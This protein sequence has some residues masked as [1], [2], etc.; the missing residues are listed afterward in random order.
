MGGNNLKQSRQLICIYVFFKVSNFSKAMKSYEIHPNAHLQ[1]VASMIKIA[2]TCDSRLMLRRRMMQMQT[3]PMI[4]ALSWSFLCVVFFRT[5]SESTAFLP[6]FPQVQLP[7]M[8]VL[9]TVQSAKLWQLVAAKGQADSA[10]SN[11]SSL[12][13][14]AQTLP[15]ICRPCPLLHECYM[16]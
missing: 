16:L 8:H 12:R 11:C 5:Y 1:D 15:W 10:S 4:Y 13:S 14:S 3:R 7:N 6:I 2:G 9:T